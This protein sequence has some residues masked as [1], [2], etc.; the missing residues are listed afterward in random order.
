MDPDLLRSYTL[1][2]TKRKEKDT[3]GSVNVPADAYYGACMS[4]NNSDTRPDFLSD[5][6]ALSL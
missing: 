5:G 6:F 3:L 1:A 2:K 4:S